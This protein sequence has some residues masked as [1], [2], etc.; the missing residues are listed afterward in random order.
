[1][2]VVADREVLLWQ[3]API[4]KLTSR[5]SPRPQLACVKLEG[6]PN[7][8]TLTA[9]DCECWLE[10]RTNAVD[11]MKRG[12]ALVPAAELAAASEAIRAGTVTMELEEDGRLRVA[13]DFERFMIPCYPVAD[14]PPVPSVVEGGKIGA[15]LL[16]RAMGACLPFVSSENSRYAIAGVG[17]MVNGAKLDAVATDGRRMA[18]FTIKAELAESVIVP[19][20]AAHLLASLLEECDDEGETVEVAANKQL[21]CARAENWS[22]WSNLIE[23]TFPPYTNHIPTA[24]A[25]TKLTVDRE[26]MIGGTRAA[27]LACD[28]G[29]AVVLDIDPEKKVV[30]IES[31][32]PDGKVAAVTVEAHAEGKPLRIGL[33]HRFLATA[34]AAFDDA[35]E[36]VLQLQGPNKPAWMRQRELFTVVMPVNLPAWTSQDQAVGSPS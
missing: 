7:L 21:V 15:A 31:R 32:G 12:A 30:S 23:G 28:D 24:D 33:N 27:S 16:I 11:I 19:T 17:L 25:P 3:L 36:V 1:M 4:V 8:L 18:V 22:L 10:R 34:L 14:F 6:S 13:G 29:Y 9:T 5:R 26:A 35:A 2:R 20:K